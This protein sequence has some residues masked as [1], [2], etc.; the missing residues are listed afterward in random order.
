MAKLSPKFVS[1]YNYL[2]FRYSDDPKMISMLK[3][4]VWYSCPIVY[5]NFIDQYRIAYAELLRI[6]AKR[7]RYREHLRKMISKYGQ[8]YLV[9]LTFGD[10]YDSTN[11]ATRKKYV[12]RW[13]N[14]YT[15]D[16]FACLDIGKKGGREH[17]HCICALDTIFTPINLSSRCSS[18]Y[19]SFPE[20]SLWSWGFSSCKAISSTSKGFGEYSALD[21]A[22]KSAIYS[23]KSADTNSQIKPFH[24]RGVD[25]T[26]PYLY[27]LTIDFE[28][29]D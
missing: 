7:K 17:Y 21:Y 15:L 18:F 6:R 2:R 8:L 22:F 16:Y 12:Q 26:K 13:L 24:K 27:Q 28:L 1:K 23:F 5:P 10:C 3:N 14:D 20:L 9:T 29:V 19:L 4:I 11:T 25:Y